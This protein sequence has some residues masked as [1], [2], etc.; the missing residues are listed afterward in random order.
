[1]R[2]E[3]GSLELALWVEAAAAKWRV[4]EFPGVGE[5]ATGSEE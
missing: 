5:W 4:R 1:M 2:A 3:R